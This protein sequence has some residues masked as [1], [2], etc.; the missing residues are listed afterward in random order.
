MT[1]IEMPEPRLSADFA[2]RVL[3]KADRVA[4]RR[5]GA[6]RLL[7]AA[8]TLSFSVIAILSWHEF[9][10]LTGRSAPRPEPFPVATSSASNPAEDAVALSYLFPDAAPVERFAAQ[11]SDTADDGGADILSDPDAPVQ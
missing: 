10:P 4:A 1:S 2:S 6:R 5:H 8:G 9:A 3:L 11:Y 7:A